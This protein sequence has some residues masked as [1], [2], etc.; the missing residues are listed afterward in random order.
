MREGVVVVEC[1]MIVVVMLVVLVVGCVVLLGEEMDNSG[2][3][4]LFFLGTAVFLNWA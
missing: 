2:V 4:Y 3:F 1:V